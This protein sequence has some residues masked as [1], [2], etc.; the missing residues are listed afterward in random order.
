MW[1]SERRRETPMNDFTMLAFA[2]AGGAVLGIA[3]YGG[4]Y[5]T[6]RR[7]LESKTPALWFSASQL[8]RSVLVLG[9]FYAISGGDWH[10]LIACLPGFLLARVVVTRWGYRSAA[11]AP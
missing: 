4:L 2:A 9:G 3:F 6:I 10:R 5:W 8:L 7:G 1:S 11:A